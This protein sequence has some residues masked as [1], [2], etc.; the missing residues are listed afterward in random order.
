MPFLQGEI[1][2]RED[3]F[4]S[5]MLFGQTLVQAG[6]YANEDIKEKVSNRTIFSYSLIMFSLWRDRIALCCDSCVVGAVS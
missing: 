6:H 2:A 3:L 5:T 4:K 1:D